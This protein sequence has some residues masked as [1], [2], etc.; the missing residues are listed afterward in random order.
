M[1]E[2]LAKFKEKTGKFFSVAGKVAIIFLSMAVGFSINEVYRNKKK[3]QTR[4]IVEKLPA[5]KTQ[6]ETSVAMNERGEVIIFDRQTGSYTIYADSVGL[7]IFNHYASRMY[8]K[9]NQK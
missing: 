4:V 7:M 2:K 5:T 3:V 8:L 9:A 1:N 6:L